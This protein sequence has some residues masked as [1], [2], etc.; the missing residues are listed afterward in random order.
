LG[1]AESPELI[2]QNNIRAMRAQIPKLNNGLARA[3]ST[4]LLLTNEIEDLE[5]HKDKVEYKLKYAIEAG[6]DKLGQS[7]AMEL[8]RTMDSIEKQKT[9]L[10]EAKKGV[11]SMQEI[12]ESHKL[13]M[14]DEINKI[15]AAVKEAKFAE[16]RGD[17]A[18]MWEEFSEHDIGF[19]NK[20]M[21]EKLNERSAFNSSKLEVINESMDMKILKMEREA[22]ESAGKELYDQF[23]QDYLSK[24][25]NGG[26]KK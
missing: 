17:I 14:T 9:A 15:K 13:R 24:N 16:L 11:E 20:E 6:E 1:T 19:S 3:K 5:N 4:V 21:L 26:N 12:V 25:K 2:L 8:Q 18:S 10:K 23:K 22:E 7:L